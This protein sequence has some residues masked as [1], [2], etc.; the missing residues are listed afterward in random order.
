MIVRVVPHDPNWSGLFGIECGRIADALGDI[1]AALHHI[2]STAVPGIPAKPIIDMLLEVSDLGELDRRAP[3]MES[4]GYEAKGE[5][6]IPGRR[7][8]RRDDE[9]RVRTHQMHAF[10]F[11]SEDVVR[12]LAFRD[13]MIAHPQIAQSYGDLKRQ[14]A[15]RFPSDMEAYMDGKDAFVKEHQAKALSWRAAWCVGRKNHE[16][17]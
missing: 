9:H 12:H 17:D 14:L 6:G 11:G 5:F 3:R 8:F 15:A 7:Y 1:V 16:R 4:L 13:Y 10:H 2:G